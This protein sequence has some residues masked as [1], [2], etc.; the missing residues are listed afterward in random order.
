MNYKL[1]AHEVEPGQN[2]YIDDGTLNLEVEKIDGD[3][4]HCK[5]VVGGALRNTKGINL[6]GSLR[7]RQRRH[8]LWYSAWHG[9][10]SCLF[11]QDRTGS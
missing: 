1:L 8:S 11:R 6:P 5:I 3:D 4:V 10:F 2:I 7:K 9:I